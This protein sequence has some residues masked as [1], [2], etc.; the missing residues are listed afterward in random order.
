MYSE[1]IFDINRKSLQIKTELMFILT[2]GTLK[3]ASSQPKNSLTGC[4][5]T[6]L[7]RKSRADSFETHAD[8]VSHLEAKLIDNLVLQDELQDNNNQDDFFQAWKWLHNTSLESEFWEDSFGTHADFV[9]RLEAKLIDN[10]VVS[11]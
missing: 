1:P 6:S 10:L 11:G 2:R 8:V 5:H 4:Q 3:S 9:S 7:K